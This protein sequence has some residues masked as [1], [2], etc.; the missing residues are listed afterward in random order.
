MIPE[1][2]NQNCLRQDLY[3][4]GRVFKLFQ[5]CCNHI[6]NL[7]SYPK[8]FSHL[9]CV[10][11]TL[12]LRVCLEKRL[13]FFLW[14]LSVY[15]CLMFKSGFLVLSFLSTCTF[16]FGSYLNF[17]SFVSLGGKYNFRFMYDYPQ[18]YLEPS[19]TSAMEFFLRK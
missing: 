1:V 15:E 3:F 5:R 10:D 12:M 17:I 11:K 13:T 7:W 2:I 14:I 16:W 18:A 19:R 6:N 8:S 9:K 4:F